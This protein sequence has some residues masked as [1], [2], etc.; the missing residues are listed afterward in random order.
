LRRA[1]LRVCID[2]EDFEPG[3][4]LLDEM[5][6]ADCESRK[7]ICVLSPDYFDGNRFVSLESH[8]ARLGDPGAQEGRLIPLLLRYTSVPAWLRNLVPIDW[9]VPEDHA[10]EWRKLLEALGAKVLDAPPPSAVDRPPSSSGRTSR[11][12][13]FEGPE[14]LPG[15]VFAVE[16]LTQ[17]ILLKRKA[18]GRLSV[19]VC[20]DK[21]RE[22]LYTT[23][24]KRRLCQEVFGSPE[25]I[26]EAHARDLDIHRFIQGQGDRRELTLPLNGLPMRWASG[27]V[28]SIVHWKGRT[29]TPFFFRD[30]APFGWNISLG[31]SEK[32]DNLNDPWTFVF[33]EFLE[34]TLVLDRAPEHASRVNFKRFVF[35]DRPHIETQV[36]SASAFAAEHIQA[37]FERDSLVMLPV[38]RLELERHI[39]LVDLRRTSVDVEILHDQRLHSAWNVLVCINLL[40]LGIEVVKVVEYSLEDSDYVL[41]GELLD[42]G[43]HQELLRMPVALISHDYLARAFGP[44]SP[45]FQ[46]L[47]GIQPSVKALALAPDDIHIFPF[48]AERRLSLLAE[49]SAASPWE[50]E[51]YSG[52]L[53]SF[54]DHFFDESGKVTNANASSLFTPASAKIASYLFSN[55]AR[56]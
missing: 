12:M 35:R 36:E 3:R 21:V 1:G 51:R 25:Q 56:G 44:G 45:D 13:V 4:D 54:G 42:V 5:A 28:L 24:S 41:D 18:D 47:G 6:R 49:G 34:E 33:R 7:V 19:M 38:N 14:R 10:R 27:G 37:R 15:Q 31:A 48:D 32:G 52:W 2:V 20:R 43:T 30:I 26:A 46:Y 8:V 40:E 55:R 16:L 11:E 22:G 50:R 9:T 29:W 17:P 53:A 39:C 23:E